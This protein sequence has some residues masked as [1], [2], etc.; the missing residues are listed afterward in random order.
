MRIYKLTIVASAVSDALGSGK[1][2]HV[3][4]HDVKKKIVDGTIFE[5]LSED[6]DLVVPVSVLEPVDK[7]E[8]LYEWENLFGCVEPFRFDAHRNGLCFLLGYSL[9]S[10]RKGHSP[11]HGV[12]RLGRGRAGKTAKSSLSRAA[13][14][15]D[16]TT[17]GQQGHRGRL[18]HLDEAD[19]IDDEI[20]VREFVF[21]IYG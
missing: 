18:G 5:F 8:L 1:F 21:G 15:S 7:L 11:V 3:T 12:A 4:H 14:Q 20:V 6:L 19:V 2:N 9:V 13:A 10:H 17:K 16:Q